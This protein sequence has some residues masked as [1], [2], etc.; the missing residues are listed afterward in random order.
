M[1]K[2][3]KQNGVTKDVITAIVS[4]NGDVELQG[5][6]KTDTTNP[7]IQIELANNKQGDLDENANGLK[8]INEIAK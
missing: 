2:Q 1:V 8:C 7:I 5:K 6:L 4:K 3:A